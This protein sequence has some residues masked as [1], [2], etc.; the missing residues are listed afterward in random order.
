MKGLPQHQPTVNRVSRVLVH[1]ETIVPFLYNRCPTACIHINRMGIN[2]YWGGTLQMERTNKKLIAVPGATRQQAGAAVRAL[3][4]TKQ[5]QVRA[6]TP[7]P[8]KRSELAD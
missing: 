4:G 5:V 2:R 3:Q 7:N 1:D 8:A 6:R